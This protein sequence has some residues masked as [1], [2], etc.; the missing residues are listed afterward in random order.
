MKRKGNKNGL[1][2]YNEI[3]KRKTAAIIVQLRMGY[4]EL[5]HY[6]HRFG[7]NGSPYYEYG[8]EKEL[9]EHYLLECK[10]YRE[11]KK[12]LR[13]EIGTGKMKIGISL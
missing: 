12:R 5:N 6:F 7:I 1:K 10:K 13:M 4:C 8:Y 11:Q 2:L 9:V 3:I